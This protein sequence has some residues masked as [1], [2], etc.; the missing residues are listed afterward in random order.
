MTSFV[1]VLA[2]V[3]TSITGRYEAP[4]ATLELHLG[5]DGQLRGHLIEEA[6]VVALDPI[7]IDGDD[8]IATARGEDD[9]RTELHAT[10]RSGGAIR[11]GKRTF[12]RKAAERPATPTV[13]RAIFAAYEKLADAVNTK[14]FDAFQALRTDDFATIPP[15]SP[16]RNAEF[17][18]ARARGLL[19][20]IQPPI[21]TRNDILTLTLRGDEAI[22]TVR[23]HFSRSQPNAQGVV[24]RVETSVTQRETWRRTPDGWKL[25]FVDEVRDFVR[26]AEDEPSVR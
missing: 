7:R 13:R 25:T 15:D 19:A 6:R 24:R 9:T 5:A 11:I 14:D 2:L 20:G 16:P 4:K 22:A 12:A 23:Q 8:L 3:A 17:M 1:V 21:K 26:W 10:V 18:A